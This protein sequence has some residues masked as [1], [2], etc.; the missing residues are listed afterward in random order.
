MSYGDALAR[1][2]TFIGAR[3]SAGQPMST[4]ELEGSVTADQPPEEE[5]TPLD[6]D[7][8]VESPGAC[9]RHVTVTVK[10]ADIQRYYD[11]A[12]SEMMESAA[13]P[14]FRAGRAPRKLVEARYRKEVTEQVKGSLLMDS[15]SQISEDQ[16]FAAISEPELDVDAI[17]VPDEGDMTFEFDL[18][19]RPEF[20]LP[21]WKGLKIERPSADIT[22]EEIDRELNSILSD[23]GRRVPTS[24]PAG[25]GDYVTADITVNDDGKAIHELPEQSICIRPTL[26]F[27]DGRIEKFDKLMKGV[28]AGETRDAKMTL[29]DDA[30]NEELAGK[31][32]E[33]AL[34][35]LDVK[36]FELPE[37][38]EDLLEE[39]GNFESEGDLRDAIRNSIERQVQYEEQQR[40]R[41]QI[42]D[43]LTEAAEWELPPELLERQS[44]RE[45]ERAVLE[46]RRSGFSQTDINAYANDLRQN[47]REKTSQAL[48]EHFIL[49]RIA[50][51]EDIEA[52]DDDYDQ[53]I[54][55]IAMQSGD[56]PRRVRAQI[57]KQNLMDALRNQIIERKV[58]DLVREHAKFKDVKRKPEDRDVVEAVDASAAGGEES[59]IPVAE[60]GEEQE[61][62]KPKDYT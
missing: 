32:V 61:L 11:E 46:M 58:I 21:N 60:H 39:V 13:V 54:A 16:D 36:R 1:K 62:A 17:E 56:T 47:S 18:E 22:D 34:K 24:D 20:D 33:V 55:L 2:H 26:S 44:K 37:M 40:V 30:A 5:T 9:Q 19:V 49:E 38:T 35:V 53:E 25:E 52:S 10:R 15:M 6:L 14:G 4:D 29:S 8:Q 51:E 43:L 50:E 42:T 27:R 7:V 23:Y 48:R 57:E 12:F 31:D 41:Q 45:L 28:K 3:L 59:Q